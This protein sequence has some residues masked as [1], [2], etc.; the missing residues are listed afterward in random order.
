[1]GVYQLLSQ[2]RLASEVNTGYLNRVVLGS[3]AKPTAYR[4]RFFVWSCYQCRIHA[5]RTAGIRLRG[6]QGVC[7]DG[8]VCLSHQ[9][10]PRSANHSVPGQMAKEAA[11]C[12]DRLDCQGVVQR[13]SEV[14]EACE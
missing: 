8:F 14:S 12:I 2:I 3:R 5:V 13:Q 6:I 10:Q 9:V 1:L 7:G 4:H 11:V